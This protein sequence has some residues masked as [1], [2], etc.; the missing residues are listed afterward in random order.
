MKET[1]EDIQVRGLSAKNNGG[2]FIKGKLPAL[3]NF[4]AARRYMTFAALLLFLAAG[5]MLFILAYRA[6]VR[7]FHVRDV[8]FSGNNHLSE[9]ELRPLAGIAEG[10]SLLGLSTNRVAKNLLKSPWIK[11][12][13]VRKDFPEKIFVKIMETSPFAILELNDRSFFIDE[14]GRMLE[15]LKENSVPFLPVVNADPFN[16][17]EGFIEAINLARAVKD[18]NIAAERSRIE[19]IS[20]Q[21]PEDLSMVVDR[22]VVKVG[23]G[24]YE[25]KLK[26]LFSLED[27]IKKRAV[28]VDYIDLRFANRVVVKPINEVMK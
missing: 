4:L 10:E 3:M 27:E 12:V 17:H 20:G 11:A 5:A 23:Y 2:T 18:K 9:T 19:I 24:D 26:R 15:E 1:G 25:Q 6:G 21:K 13:S 22:V 28:A 7:Q 16:N 8:V 14:K